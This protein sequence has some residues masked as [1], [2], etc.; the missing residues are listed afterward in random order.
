MRQ[1]PDSLSVI[2][3]VLRPCPDSSRNASRL[4]NPEPSETDVC[5]KF[6]KQNMPGCGG[7]SL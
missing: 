3:K 5:Q 6:Q 7:F 1:H 4:T 2:S